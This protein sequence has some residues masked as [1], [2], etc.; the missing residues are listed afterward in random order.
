M[1]FKFTKRRK[2]IAAVV[3][4]LLLIYWFSLPE[5]LF[6]NPTSTVVLSS[7]K[8][9]MGARIAKDGQWRFP[10]SDSVPVKFKK[11]IIAFEDQYFYYH[12]GVNLISLGRAAYQDVKAR[13]IVSGG[14]TLTMQVARLSSKHKKRNLWYKML[15][16]IL[17]T[18]IEIAYSKDEIL[19]LYAS[20]APFGGNVVGLNAA[21]WRFYHRSA[22]QLSWAET[23][24]IAVLPN[25]PSLIHPGKQEA[26]VG[27]E[28]QIA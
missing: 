16:I 10:Q 27:Q 5:K 4:L 28:K 12:P 18:R 7:D 23:A 14:S 25:A 6:N 21:S 13:K 24:T 8:Y 26:V 11:C 19:N 22:F 3:I 9:L 17:A 2:I 20:N 15:E 1:K